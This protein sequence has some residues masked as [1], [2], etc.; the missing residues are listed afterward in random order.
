MANWNMYLFFSPYE[1]LPIMNFFPMIL[2]Y[3]KQD[4]FCNRLLCQNPV[5]L[6]RAWAA[7]R[8]SPVVAVVL[9]CNCSTSV[10]LAA[11]FF[12]GGGWQILVV[13]CS[14]RKRRVAVS[15]LLYLWMPHYRYICSGICYCEMHVPWNVQTFLV[16]STACC[17][18]DLWLCS[19]WYHIQSRRFVLW[20]GCSTDWAT[21]GPYCCSINCW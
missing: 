19:H 14:S 18:L 11:F 3:A 16:S 7:I 12:G 2:S 8:T 21:A 4:P 17:A 10:L 9:N 6:T 20:F 5:L 13:A 15:C 1:S